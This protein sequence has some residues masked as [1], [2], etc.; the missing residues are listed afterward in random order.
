MAL[1]S[2]EA[3]LFGLC[4]PG[5]IAAQVNDLSRRPGRHHAARRN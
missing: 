3:V 5:R 4:K 2:A 1:W